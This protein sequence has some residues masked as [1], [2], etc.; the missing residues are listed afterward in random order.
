MFGL[1]AGVV[2]GFLARG[3]LISAVAERDEQATHLRY[4]AMHD[5]LT[6][7]LAGHEF[8]AELARAAGSPEPGRKV[9]IF[10]DLD[11][12]KPINDRYGHA[13]G[14]AVLVQVAARLRQSVR[15]HDV[16][17]RM[18][19]DEFAVL[20]S[21]EGTFQADDIAQRLLLAI[22]R[23]VEYL[24][25]SLSVSASIG[26]AHLGSVEAEDLLAA[27]DVAMYQA[28]AAGGGRWKEVGRRTRS[29]TAAGA[30]QVETR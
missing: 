19:G 5:G 3:M 11:G 25:Q 28:K 27:A 6:K 8:R 16:V 1:L 24:G 9:L 26:I 14:D 29:T 15:A 13:A 12:F 2:S 23:P 10:I 30:A 4:R 22:Q 20:A 18:G 21:L 17:G 7:V